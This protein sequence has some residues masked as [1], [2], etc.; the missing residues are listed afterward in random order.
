MKQIKFHHDEL[1][2]VW[3]RHTIGVDAETI[4]EAENLLRENGIANKGAWE[5]DDCGGRIQLLE[6]GRFL[7]VQDHITV[8]EN[9][10]IP[11]IVIQTPDNHAVAD[12]CENRHYLA[13]SGGW[14][15]RAIE[16]IKRRFEA[17][18]DKIIEFADNYWAN[19]SSDE[20]NLFGFD[21]WLHGGEPFRKKGKKELWAFLFPLDEMERNASNGEIVAA[22]E[23][24]DNDDRDY[25][26]ERLTPDEFACRCNDNEYADQRQWVRFILL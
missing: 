22:Y 1:A 15:D 20:D 9:G 21:L 8:E 17:P 7:D 14:R 25:P 3:R 11:T 23:H 5:S 10:G 12:N 13:E 26:V 2:S 18:E 16:L 24:E 6:S 19:D 4:E